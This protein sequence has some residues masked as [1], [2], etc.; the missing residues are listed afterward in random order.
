MMKQDQIPEKWDKE[1]DLVS[2]G[3]SSGGLTAAIIAHDLGLSTILLEKSEFLGGGTALSGGILWIPFNHHMQAEGIGDSRDEAMLHIRSISMGRHDEEQMA[4][5]LDTGPEAVRYLE[6]H[7][8]LKLA[9]DASPD[10]YADLPGGKKHGRQLFPDPATMTPMLTEAAKT[11]PLLSKVR[12][13][14]VPFF[15]GMRDPW[16]EGRALIGPLVMACVDRGIEILTGIRAKQL[17]VQEGKIIGLRAEREGKDFFVKARRGVLLA[18]GGYEWNKEMNCRFMNCPDLRPITPNSN[19]GDGHIM[20]ME[21]GAAVA[22][23]DHSIYQ[24]T[25]KVEGEDIEGRPFNRPISYGYPGSILVNRYGKRCCNE[26]FYPDIGRAMVAYDKVR[27]ELPN[28]PLFWIGDQQNVERT[29]INM[30]AAITP[31]AA[32]L[33]KADTLPELAQQLGISADVLVETVERFNTNAQEGRDPDFHRG[34]TTYETFWGSKFYPGH[35]PNPTLGPVGQ[36]PYYGVK[37]FAGSVGN[38]GGLVVNKNS[39]VMNTQGEVIPGLYATSNTTA[40][41][42]H[43]F[44]YTSGACQA[45]SLIFGYIAARHM[46]QK[47]WELK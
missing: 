46:A 11:H 42:S 36:P 8:P 3:S 39:Q 34:E 26:S 44:S 37:L 14:P 35:G 45:K 6:E 41:L 10:Y 32:W 24:P 29:F 15:L 28:N 1:V 31:N 13:D 9:I 40:L 23:M 30:L 47:G 21:V 5:Y 7:T 2:V 19:E 18:T 43:G 33:H 16:S 17:I 22:L 38:L 20:G 25:Y 4:T 12:S 27:A